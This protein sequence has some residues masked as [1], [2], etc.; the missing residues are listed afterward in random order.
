MRERFL[1][2]REVS[3]PL[4][5]RELCETFGEWTDEEK[6]SVIEVGTLAK[7]KAEARN[8]RPGRV[9]D[10][11]L[12]LPLF[13]NGVAYLPSKDIEIARAEL[14]LTEWK[15]AAQ[16]KTQKGKEAIAEGNLML[17]FAKEAKELWTANPFLT[18]RQVFQQLKAESQSA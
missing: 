12:P 11:Q 1:A 18:A 2:E 9:A 6:Q 7:L 16:Y 15:E 4:L 14:R 13:M 10:G 8:L 17:Q 5:A 3:L